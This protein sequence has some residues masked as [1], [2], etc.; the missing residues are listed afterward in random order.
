MLHHTV[1]LLQIY[2]GG[3][4]SDSSKEIAWRENIG[5]KYLD[6]GKKGKERKKV[7]KGRESDAEESGE[8]RQEEGGK[9]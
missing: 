4:P 3:G 5:G 6:G 7:K 9:Q 1:R 2:T 8:G